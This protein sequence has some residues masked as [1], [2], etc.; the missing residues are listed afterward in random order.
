MQCQQVIRLLLALHFSSL[1]FFVLTSVSYVTF[2]FPLSQQ[3]R[4]IGH[5]EWRRAI[6]PW[7]LLAF[8]IPASDSGQQSPFPPSCYCEKYLREVL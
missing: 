3:D 8:T 1:L 2:G 6:G 4:H 7:W 5:R